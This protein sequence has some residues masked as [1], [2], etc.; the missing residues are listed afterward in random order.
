M[1]KRTS[2]PNDWSSSHNAMSVDAS[3]PVMGATA[4]AQSREARDPSSH[5]RM[6]SLSLSLPWRRPKDSMRDLPQQ[7]SEV[8]IDD[9][10]DYSGQPRPRGLS[11]GH[12]PHHHSGSIKGIFRRASISLRGV[13]RRRP[14]VATE[15]AIFEE[16]PMPTDRRPTTSH[17]PWNRPRPQTGVRHSR[18]FYGLD[19]TPEPLPMTRRPTYTSYNCN[20]RPGLGSEPPIIPR[21]TGAAAKASAAMQNEFL[22]RA[23]IQNLWLHPT[24]SEDNNDDESGVGISVSVPGASEAHISRVDFIQALPTELAT[25]ILAY[26]DAAA[27]AKAS[28]VSRAWRQVVN[29]Q[30]VW[31]ESCLRELT[32]TYAM[33]GPVRPSV[34]LGLPRSLPGTDWRQVY[35][36]KKD[37]DQ[38][39]KEGRARPVYLNGHTDSIYCLQFD[40]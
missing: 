15:A 24:A 3:E 27:L 38:R 26:L 16:Q 34:G 18:S 22:A 11:H 21:S 6:R 20:T 35:R 40:E 12:A 9:E 17:L 33:S 4:N 13:V 25:H 2:P 37:L 31:R 5:H 23:G 32:G 39:W 1:M 10:A 8:A 36:T 28:R 30:Y 7:L 19:F 29:E 14:S